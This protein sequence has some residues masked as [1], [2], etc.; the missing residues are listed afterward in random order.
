MPVTADVEGEEQPK[1][2]LKSSAKVIYLGVSCNPVCF[3]KIKKEQG[4]KDRALEHS[5]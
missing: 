5:T 2:N 4:T 1:N 3:M